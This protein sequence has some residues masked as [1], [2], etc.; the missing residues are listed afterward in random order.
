MEAKSIPLTV[1]LIFEGLCHLEGTQTESHKKLFPFLKMTD[2]NSDVPTHH[3]TSL[4][5]ET[6]RIT[7]QR[8]CKCV[9]GYEI[10]YLKKQTNWV[11]L[12]KA[13]LA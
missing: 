13:S 3:T 5:P 9:V 7:F 11:Q 8:R 6:Q 4:L 12:F 1:D 10:K 2:K